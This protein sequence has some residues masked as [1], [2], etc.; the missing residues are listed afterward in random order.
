MGEDQ[1][2]DL[3][4]LSDVGFASIFP[5]KSTFIGAQPPFYAMKSKEKTIIITGFPLL[6]PVAR[7]GLE[8]PYCRQLK[9]PPPCS[10]WRKKTESAMNLSMLTSCNNPKLIICD[11][12]SVS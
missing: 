7:E 2:F 10:S 12:P 6:T 8:Q 3:N 9:K 1:R 5:V 11:G 4:C